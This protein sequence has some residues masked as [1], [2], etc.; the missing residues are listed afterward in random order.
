MRLSLAGL[1][2]ERIPGAGHYLQEER[3]D[4]VADAVRL[5]ADATPVTAAR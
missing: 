1:T 2:T 3:P 4:V 5:V